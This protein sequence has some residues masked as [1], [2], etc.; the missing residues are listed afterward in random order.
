ML[1]RIL[2]VKHRISAKS[3]AGWKKYF[4]VFPCVLG[5]NDLSLLKT[6]GVAECLTYM[7]TC[8]TIVS[9]VMGVFSFFLQFAFFF[10]FFKAIIV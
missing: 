1:D 7:L 8:L 3:P 2:Q 5:K 9:R 6:Y 4:T 10:F